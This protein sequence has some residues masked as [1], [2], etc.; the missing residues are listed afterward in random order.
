[1]I[2]LKTNDYIKYV[3]EQVVSYVDQPKEEKRARKEEKRNMQQ[4]KAY[5][6]FGLI[7]FAIS[8]TYKQWRNKE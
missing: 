3:T 6:L 8:Q 5:Q 2:R 1:M 4:P 7:P